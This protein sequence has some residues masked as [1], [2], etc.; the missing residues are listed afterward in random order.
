MKKLSYLLLILAA[1]FVLSPV[2]TSCDDL[3]KDQLEEQAD[4]QEAYLPIEYAKKTVAAW[5]MLTEQESNKTRIEAVFLFEDSTL[6]VTK[7]KIYSESDGRKPEYSIIDMGQYVFLNEGDDYTN[8]EAR[9]FTRSGKQFVAEIKDGNLSVPMGE[10]GTDVVFT[11]MSNSLLPKAYDPKSDNQGGNNQGGDNQGGD[12]QGDSLVAFFPNEFKDKTVSAWF[13][14]ALDTIAEQGYEMKSVSAVYFF[15]DNSYVVTFNAIISMP[16]QD[17]PMY[18]AE[19]L[20]NGSYSVIEGDFKNGKISISYGKDSSMIL[21][22]RDGNIRIVNERTQEV[23]DYAIQD[24]SN[25]PQASDP[26]QNGNWGGNGDQ[27]GEDNQGGNSQNTDSIYSQLAYYPAQL[28]KNEIAAWYTLVDKYQDANVMELRIEAIFLFKDNTYAVTEFKAHYGADA[29]K[30]E[31]YIHSQGT[32]SVT[33]G[34]YNNGWASISPNNGNPFDVKIENGDVYV[35]DK[36]YHRQANLPS[37]TQNDGGDD[38]PQGGDDN[39]QGGDDN[40]QGGDDNPQGGDDNPQEG[41][42]MYFNDSIYSSLAYFPAKYSDKKVAAWYVLASTEKDRTRV[43]AIYLFNDNTLV[44]TKSKYYFDGQKPEFDIVAEGQ[45]R[46]SQGDYTNG[47]ANVKSDDGSFDV[48]IENGSLSAMDA[49]FSKMDNSSVPY[50]NNGYDNIPQGGDDKPHGGDDYPQGGDSIIGPQTFD[51]DIIMP[52]LP[53]DY[54]EKP[55]AACYMNFEEDE[56]SIKFE[57]VYLFQDS[58]LIVTKAKFYSLDDG[59][60]PK[61]EVLAQGKYVMVRGDFSTGVADVTL[62]DGTTFEVEIS[63][64][65]MFAMNEEFYLQ[66]GEAVMTEESDYILK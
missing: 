20:E 60:Q 59:R 55:L 19:V 25:V 45:Y 64:G 10:E 38:N 5:Y 61:K 46:I 47:S 3:L 34:D 4:G 63:Q 12:V 62:V 1:A 53:D 24:N 16:M 33:K 30:P 39:P 15:N 22:V 29:Q 51:Y 28:A 9:V 18:R 48:T 32:F 40:P 44:V 42:N 8:G 57:S 66:S 58:T 54:V 36:T 7:A 23:S 17:G 13:S 11:K 21:V 65:V 14:Y 6:V 41:G 49:T 50:N 56:A 27:G 35:Q 2:F 43:E 26:T 31:Y 52:Y 37:V